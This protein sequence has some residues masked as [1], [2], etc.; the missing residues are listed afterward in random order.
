LDGG[1]THQAGRLTEWDVPY[2]DLFRYAGR[3]ACRCVKAL[4]MTRSKRD[5]GW[6]GRV[7]KQNQD[8]A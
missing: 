1:E 7:L 4:E 6:Q 8:K 2:E 5:K 3:H